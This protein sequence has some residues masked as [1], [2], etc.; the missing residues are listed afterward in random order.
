MVP[1]L[2]QLSAIWFLPE[3]PRWLIS[4]DRGDEAMAALIQYHGDGVETELVRLEYAEICAAIDLEKSTGNTTW[5]SMVSTPGNRYRMFLVVCMGTFS[6]WSGNGLVSYC[7]YPIVPHLAFP[8]ASLEQRTN[9]A[10]Y[11]PRSDH[12]QHRN[13]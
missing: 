12:G 2:I 13:N 7:E 3:S 10:L 5:K 8:A 1:S 4:H 11:R 6:Q 9:L